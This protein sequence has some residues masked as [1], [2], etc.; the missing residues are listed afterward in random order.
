MKIHKMLLKPTQ[1]PWSSPKSPWNI[2][3]ALT[4]TSLDSLKLR[5]HP[6]KLCET[7]LKIAPQKGHLIASYSSLKFLG[8]PEKSPW[9][10]WSLLTLECV[11][12]LFKRSCFEVPW[13]PE[14][15]YKL[16]ET[17]WLVPEAIESPIWNSLESPFESFFFIFKVPHTKTNPRN[18]LEP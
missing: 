3:E 5:W 6:L 4:E 8:T 13:I 15:F 12:N 1:T 14:I 7:P 17:A 11:W 9:D 2:P 16:Y 18:Q 10:T